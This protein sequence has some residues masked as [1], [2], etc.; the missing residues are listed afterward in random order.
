MLTSLA[1]GHCPPNQEDNV[2]SKM[3]PHTH[4]HRTGVH[5]CGTHFTAQ[6]EIEDCT[7]H[8]GVPRIVGVVPMAK[9]QVRAP[10]VIQGTKLAPLLSGATLLSEPPPLPRPQVPQHIARLM[11]R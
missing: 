3:G 10:I 7:P 4:P 1:P 5:R 2:P 9:R 6:A 8:R 11:Y